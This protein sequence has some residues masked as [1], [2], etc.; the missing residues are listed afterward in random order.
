MF[1]FSSESQENSVGAYLLVRFTFLLVV[2]N[3]NAFLDFEV[4]LVKAPDLKIGFP[5]IM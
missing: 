5:E 2:S 4:F 1:A 3:R